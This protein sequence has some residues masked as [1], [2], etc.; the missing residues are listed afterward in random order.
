MHYQPEKAKY[1]QHEPNK[2]PD[3]YYLLVTSIYGDYLKHRLI[4]CGELSC[5]EALKRDMQLYNHYDTNFSI[6]IRSR[7]DM[8]SWSYPMQTILNI[9]KESD[10]VRFRILSKLQQYC[11]EVHERMR[12]AT[13]YFPSKIYIESENEA[14]TPIKIPVNKIDE[15]KEIDLRIK[16]REKELADADRE[17]DRFL[18]ECDEVKAGCNYND[19]YDKPW[20]YIVI[21]VISLAVLST[22]LANLPL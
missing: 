17:L 19:G 7:E 6:V 8:L 2:L 15:V 11:L 1:K 12:Q 16:L 10:I 4:Y 9:F 5:A 3:G 18:A 20:A 22:I 21:I 14:T 13:F